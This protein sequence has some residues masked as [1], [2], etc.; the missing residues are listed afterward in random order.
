[1]SRPLVF[2]C[3]AFATGR[4]RLA[5]LV[6]DLG[7]MRRRAAGI[8]RRARVAPRASSSWPEWQTTGE[9]QGGNAP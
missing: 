5:D 8:A 9:G 1:M 2:G 4:E 7:E 3:W 6:E